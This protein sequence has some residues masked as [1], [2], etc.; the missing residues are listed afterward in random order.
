MAGVK[1]GSAVAFRVLHDRY[2]HRAYRVARSVCRDDGRA[3]EV[4]QEAFLSIWTTGMQY[5]DARGVAPWLLT[6]VRH[7]AI[8]SARREQRHTLHRARQE[9]LD[10][11][12]APDSVVGQVVAGDV[13]HH[14]SILLEVLPAE[15]R[16][17]IELSFFEQLS[18]REIASRLHLPLGTVKGRIRLGID[19]LR[20]DVSDVVCG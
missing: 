14:L 8:D 12:A 1:A 15:Q 4:V 5:Q 18:H 16:E 6:V 13:V 2:R 9:C 17:A 10:E 7:R 20:G 19:R 11:V 3:Q